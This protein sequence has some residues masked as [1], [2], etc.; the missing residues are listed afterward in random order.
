M[1]EVDEIAL[2]VLREQFAEEQELLRGMLL[3]IQAYIASGLPMPREPLVLA[4]FTNSPDS[5]NRLRF[6]ISE[7]ERVV[8]RT[9][10]PHRR[11]QP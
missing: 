7:I 6:L 11:N 1:S 9:E 3:V 8:N 4:A 10:H 2:R 5:M